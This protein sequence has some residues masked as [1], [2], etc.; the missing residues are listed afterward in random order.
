MITYI[1]VGW[2]GS[3]DE[4]V[5]SCFWAAAL[6]GI[7]V[8]ES[9]VAGNPFRLMNNYLGIAAVCVCFLFGK[10]AVHGTMTARCGKSA[11]PHRAGRQVLKS[12]L[13][14]IMLCSP[15]S[16]CHL[17]YLHYTYLCHYNPSTPGWRRCSLLCSVRRQYSN[18]LAALSSPWYRR[19]D[20][21]MCLEVCTKPAVAQGSPAKYDQSKEWWSRF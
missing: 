15:T 6:G 16:T 1:H 12:D 2:T 5:G 14:T 20:K 18:T 7:A 21:R 19:K 11:E 10:V 9:T 17:Q 13:R 3:F 8:K 4:W